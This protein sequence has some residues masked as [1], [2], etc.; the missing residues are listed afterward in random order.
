MKGTFILNNLAAVERFKHEISEYDWKKPLTLQYKPFSKKRSL[1]QNALKSVWYREAALMIPSD[2]ETEE[3]FCKLHFGVP[4]LRAENEK[5]RKLYDKVMGRGFTILTYE[6]KLEAMD[7]LP[8][9]S[10]MQTDQMTDYLNRMQ[11]HYAK[12]YGIAL[13]STNE[14]SQ[15]AA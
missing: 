13:V 15:H 7:I 9:T 11:V 5:F 10:L 3:R 12:Q 8:V 4:I 1:D 2:E 14:D 6:E